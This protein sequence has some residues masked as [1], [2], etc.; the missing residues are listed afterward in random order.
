MAYY[1]WGGTTGTNVGRHGPLTKGDIVDLT[2]EEVLS[3][4]G[5]ANWAPKPTIADKKLLVLNADTTLTNAQS[6]VR[7]LSVKTSAAAYTLPAAPDLGVNY[8]FQFGPAASGDITIN[9][10]GK[11]I[12]GA[13]SNLTLAIAS[14]LCT[15]VYYNGTQWISY[16]A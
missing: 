12:D 8:E 9:R 13:A 2:A 15:G 10:N 3:V 4:A 11:E 6:G 5:N 16:T 14:V 7:V 1:I